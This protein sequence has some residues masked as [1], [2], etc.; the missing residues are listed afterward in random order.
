MCPKSLGTQFLKKL[1][2]ATD[3]DE[4]LHLLTALLPELLL[5]SKGRATLLIQSFC[6]LA[7]GSQ[8]R[9]VNLFPAGRKPTANQCLLFELLC[10]LPQQ[11]LLLQCPFQVRFSYLKF[12]PTKREDFVERKRE[13]L[14]RFWA[15]ARRSATVCSMGW[16]AA[17]S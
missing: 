16:Y 17:M 13:P 9:A 2:I 3:L 10:P 15:R 6:I 14:H 7:G 11:R 5:R 1:D 12:A 4:T 8:G